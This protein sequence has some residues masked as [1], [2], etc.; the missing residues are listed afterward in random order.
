MKRKIIFFVF[1]CV[2]TGACATEPQEILTASPEI[3]YQKGYDAFQKKEYAEA[4]KYFDEVERQHPYSIWSGRAQIMAAY[5]FYQ[6]NKYDEAILA[7]DR[8]IQL[9]PSNRNTPYAYYLKGLCYFEQMSDVQRDQRMTEEALNTFEE[10]LARF[11]NSI[12]TADV[13]AKLNQISNY[14]SGKEVAVGRY[15]QKRNDPLPAMNRF[16]E[17]VLYYP[18]SSQAPEAFYRLAA[19]YRMLGLS[20]Q[21]QIISEYMKKTYPDSEWTQ[22]AE[23]L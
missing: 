2:L 8:F 20:D 4:A 19:C 21:V 1:L 3:L 13:S 14:L 23:K 11:P 6:Q 22:K 10:F 17:A 5:A 12:Y 9:H 16:K 18:E 15:Y 7:L